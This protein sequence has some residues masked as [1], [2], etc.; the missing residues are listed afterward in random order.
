MTMTRK[1]IRED[2]ILKR[3]KEE[4]PTIGEILSENPNLKESELFELLKNSVND[5]DSFCMSY[6]DR[7]SREWFLELLKGRE[8]QNNMNL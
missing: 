4:Y 7:I 3:G 8:H 6:D 1:Q 5:P 2:K